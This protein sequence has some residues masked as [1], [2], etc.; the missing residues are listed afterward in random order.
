MHISPDVWGPFFWSTM[1]IVA[2]GYPTKPN[3]SDKRSAKE[4]FEALTR[5]IPCAICRE[6]YTAHIKELPI[7]SSLDSRQDLFRWTI[8]LHNKVNKMLNKPEKTEVE[9]VKYYEL[10]GA[11][12]R[13]PIWNHDD[14]SEMNMRSYINGLAVGAAAVAAIGGFFY[15]Y[16]E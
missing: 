12:G 5:L 2:L 15:Y 8:T 14:L 6:H 1:H 4:F 7:S 16:K 10:L 11:R 9:V 3:Y 13:S